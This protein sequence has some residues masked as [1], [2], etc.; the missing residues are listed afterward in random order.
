MRL[1]HVYL[2]FG[3][4]GTVLPYWKF[5]PWVMEHGLNLALLCQELFATR[6]GAFFGFDVVI[7][8][9]RP[10]RL[11]SL[12]KRVDA[13]CRCLGCRPSRLCS[14]TSRSFCPC[15]FLA[16]TP[17]RSRGGRVDLNPFN[18]NFP[19]RHAPAV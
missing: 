18:P 5:L 3:L 2:F 8:R 6:I 17:T 14:S 1:R 11:S 9:D 16:A 15:S 4:V 13:R 12:P 19:C 10:L 7:F